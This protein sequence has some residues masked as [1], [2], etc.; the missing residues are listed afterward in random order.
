M[1]AP[2]AKHAAAPA[3]Q[4]RGGGHL[5]LPARWH[6]PAVLKWLRRTHAWLGMWGAVLGLLFGTTGLLLNHRATMKIPGAAYANS[7]SQMA[8]PQPLRRTSTPW[9]ACCSTPC[10]STALRH[11]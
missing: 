3:R 2:P 4:P 9:A 5:F 7:Q 10:T 6:R 8:L 11:S 1:L